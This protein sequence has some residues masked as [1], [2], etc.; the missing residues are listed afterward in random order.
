MA[1]K[2]QVWVVIPK[3]DPSLAR[4]FSNQKNAEIWFGD[5]FFAHRRD[6]RHLDDV[7][8]DGYFIDNLGRRYT[9]NSFFV[10]D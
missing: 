9:I 4:V 2:Q 3:E 10:E 8:D 1:T 6:A 7:L 5:L